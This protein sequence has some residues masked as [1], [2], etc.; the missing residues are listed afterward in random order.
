VII[1]SAVTGAMDAMSFLGLGRVFTSVMTANMVFLG[2]SAGKRDTTLAL[3]VG[4][5]LV[6]FVGTTLIG[7]R[8]LAE[9]RPGDPHPI[10]PRR[11][12][13]ALAVESIVL[14]AV[15]V[16]WEIVAARPHGAAQYLLLAGAAAVMGIQGAAIRSLGVTGLSTTYLT[17]LFTTVL[18]GIV[19]KDDPDFRRRGLL[20]LLAL[21]LGAAG[22]S[23]LFVEAPGLL[24]V[25][26]LVLLAGVIGAVLLR[27]QGDWKQQQERTCGSEWS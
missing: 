18:T 19:R 5:V 15:T 16:G 1:L 14:V 20:I 7:A 4:T 21:V 22:G 11:V 12:S 17:G 13:V 9:P 24:P 8:L 3:H 23:A 27:S 6:I 2:I 26:P 10:W 25:F